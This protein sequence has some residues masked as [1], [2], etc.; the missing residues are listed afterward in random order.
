MV[1]QLPSTIPIVDILMLLRGPLLVSEKEIRAL[2]IRVIRYALNTAEDVRAFEGLIENYITLLKL[3]FYYD[4]VISVLFN[5]IKA[6]CLAPLIVRI[7]DTND[8]EN[9]FEDRSQAFR[10]I[11]KLLKGNYK[12]ETLDA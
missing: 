2:A 7:I 3:F 6:G 9:T 8:G 10:L 11:R 4:I 5:Q 12:I 1:G